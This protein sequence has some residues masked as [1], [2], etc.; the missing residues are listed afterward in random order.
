MEKLRFASGNSVTLVPNGIQDMEESM[1]IRIQLGEKGI[2]DIEA[3]L[4]AEDLE[5]IGLYGENGKLVQNYNGYKYIKRVS[6]IFDVP[7]DIEKIEDTEKSEE[8]AELQENTEESAQDVSLSTKPVKTYHNELVYGD[9][10]EIVL[11]K[12]DLRKDVEEMQE[13]QNNILV[14]MLEG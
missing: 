4:Q 13:V 2:D 10:A 14:A 7:V 5:K 6:K 8:T 9:A 12:S 3:D 11:C 1:T